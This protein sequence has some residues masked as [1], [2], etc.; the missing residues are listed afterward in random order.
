MS[1]RPALKGAAFN[2]SSGRAGVGPRMHGMPGN[3]RYARKA[4]D[5]LLLEINFVDTIGHCFESHRLPNK[6]SADKALAAVPF[7]VAAIAHP[8]ALPPKGIFHRRQLHRHRADCSANTSAQARAGPRLR[9]DARDCRSGS[10]P[11]RRRFC[12]ATL[13]A[14][15]LADIGSA[16]PDAFVRAHRC[17]RGELA[18][19]TPPRCP[20]AATTRSSARAPER[21]CHQRARHCLPESILGSP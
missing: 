12:A 5:Q 8:P 3:I 18:G 21:L 6:G 16:R 11:R 2:D 13:G 17:L 4:S 9:E 15:G 7:D 14:G 19:Q 1:V 20:S 10:R